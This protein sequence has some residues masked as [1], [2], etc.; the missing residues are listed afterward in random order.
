MKCAGPSAHFACAG[1]LRE[2]SAMKAKPK[3][4]NAALAA[5]LLLCL[6]GCGETSTVDR[7]TA[8]GAGVGA[9][10]GSALTGGNAAGAAGGATVGALVGHEVGQD[11]KQTQAPKK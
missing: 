9:V 4:R 2:G 5:A 10:A 3:F 11:T 8:I 1:V 6:G 7:D